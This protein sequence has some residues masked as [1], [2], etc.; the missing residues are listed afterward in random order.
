MP[1]LAKIIAK[2]DAY[3]VIL[4]TIDATYKEDI[5]YE[6]LNE[7]IGTVADAQEKADKEFLYSLRAKRLNVLICGLFIKFF[8]STN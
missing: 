4:A 2:I 8:L 6:A 1:N 7:L 3:K 5:D